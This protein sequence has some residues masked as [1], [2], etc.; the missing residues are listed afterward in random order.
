MSPKKR[1]RHVELS[2]KGLN[3]I[4]MYLNYGINTQ[5]IAENLD[6]EPKDWITFLE[7]NS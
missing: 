2:E 3:A 7:Q 5:T 6:K 4:Q 1:N